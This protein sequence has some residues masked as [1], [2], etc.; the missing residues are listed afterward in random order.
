MVG[1][2]LIVNTFSI[3]V[4]QRSRE[5]A[6]LRALG[7]SKRQV[8]WSVLLEAFVLGVL[9]STLGLGLGVVLAMG[10]RSFFS[11]FGLDLSGQSLI[12]EPR[13]VLAAYGV[14]VVVTM[15]AA[16]LPARRTTRIAPVQALRD[17]VAMPESSLHRRLLLGVVLIVAGGGRARCRAVRRRAAHRL[18]RR[19]PACS[20]SC[21]ASPR[22]AR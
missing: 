5:L 17:D 22:P 21:S 19:W 8:T 12:F 3:L 2:F 13:T 1:A 16:W 14:G 20:A 10:I 18:V 7:A 11:R 9:G 15:A 6:L 4:A